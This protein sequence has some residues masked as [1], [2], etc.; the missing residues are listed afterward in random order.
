MTSGFSNIL[1]II[2]LIGVEEINKQHKKDIEVMDS[3]I[4]KLKT[5]Q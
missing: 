4:D 5:E 3:L 2:K 1:E